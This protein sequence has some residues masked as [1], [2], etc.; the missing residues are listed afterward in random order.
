MHPLNVAAEIYARSV[1]QFLKVPPE[2]IHKG[3]PDDLKPRH[4]DEREDAR[5]P[6]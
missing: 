2:I 1:R 3:G 5:Q 4:S 6:E